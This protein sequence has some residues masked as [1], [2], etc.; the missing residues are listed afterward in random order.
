VEII[1]HYDPLPDPAEITINEERAI[2]W[3]KVGAQPSDTAAKLLSKTGVL[4]KAGL[5]TAPKASAPAA[6]APAKA[7][8]RAKAPAAAPSPKAQAKGQQP[9]QETP[10]A[11]TGQ[12]PSPDTME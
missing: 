1:G 11:E 12:E 8:A 3:L 9:E 2:H 5:K 4:E 6:A 7:R 10:Q